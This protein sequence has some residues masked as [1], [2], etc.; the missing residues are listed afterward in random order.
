MRL[1]SLLVFELWVIRGLSN[2]L[3]IMRDF[4]VMAQA[5]AEE[6]LEL[7]GFYDAGDGTV[8]DIDAD[9]SALV[10]NSQGGIENG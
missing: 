7:M 1:K 10:N 3:C 9:D 4:L 2:A 6:R 8:C 5:E